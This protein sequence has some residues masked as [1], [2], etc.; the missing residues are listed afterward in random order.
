MRRLFATL[1][2][3]LLVITQF[4]V[5]FIAD[6]GIRLRTLNFKLSGKAIGY[7]LHFAP[8][9]QVI[10][11]CAYRKLSGAS[12]TVFRGFQSA[13]SAFVVVRQYSTPQETPPEAAVC[14]L[15]QSAVIA[16]LAVTAVLS[17]VKSTIPHTMK[18]Q[19]SPLQYRRV[20]ST[21]SYRRRPSVDTL[22]LVRSQ[23][24]SRHLKT[25]LQTGSSSRVD[26]ASTVEFDS[27]ADITLSPPV[28]FITWSTCRQNLF[29]SL[30]LGQTA[31]ASEPTGASK[32]LLVIYRIRQLLVFKS[33]V[34]CADRRQYCCI[35]SFLGA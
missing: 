21:Q 31:A 27:F 29:W 34:F 11:Q 2:T 23:I 20:H 28:K 19:G 35:H 25:L 8:G 4:G 24:A 9:L 10:S 33:T 13:R 18:C 26:S 30:P 3:I 6:C 15:Q 7:I 16:V 32:I 14:Y 22:K 5:G 1:S 17:G 12:N